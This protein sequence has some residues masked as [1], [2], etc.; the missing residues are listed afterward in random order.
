MLCATLASAQIQIGDNLHATMN[1]TVGFG[2]SGAYGNVSQSGHGIGFGFNG[3][4]NG[5]YFN[6]NFINFDFRPYFDRMQSNS[7]SQSIAR[8]TGIGGSAAFFGNSY[9]PG[10]ISYGRD[11]SNNSEYNVAGVPSV[12]TD[13][14]SQTF[15]VTWSLLLPN[16]PTLTATYGIGSSS[17][18]ITGTDME[19]S[20]SNKN[21]TL[22]SHY[23]LAGWDMYGAYGH[24]S[25]NF[26]TPAF[27]TGTSQELSSDGTQWTFNANHKIPIDGSVS[28]G[29]S[30]QHSSND[31]GDHSGGTSYS[32]SAGITP[33]GRLGLA[34]SI[35]YS[36]N[37]AESLAYS[38]LGPAAGS[39]QLIDHNAQTLFLSSSASLYVLRGLSINGHIT[40]RQEDYGFG[41][42]S[43][44]QYGGTVSYHTSH[45]WLG[46]YY[47]SGGVIDS[48]NKLG[49]TGVG[50]TGTVGMD[51]Q[52]GHWNVSAD[53]NYMQNV[54]TL[55]SIAT[56]SNM[57][58]GGSVRRRLNQSTFVSLFGRSTHSGLVTVE[59]TNNMSN[60]FGASFAWNGYSFSGNYSQSNGTGVLS[61]TGTLVPTPIGPVFTPDFIYFDAKALGVSA[62]KRFFRKFLVTSSYSQVK[63]STDQKLGLNRNSGDRFSVNTTY[64]FRRVSIV[65]GFTRSSQEF[66]TL[67]GGP[68][69]IN[70]YYFSI[71]RWFNIF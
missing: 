51:R 25:S 18:N 66:S 26:T 20:G 65:G 46:S 14:S 52:F 58:Y 13:S 23:K 19:S 30:H 12:L 54:Q 44:T 27:L 56:T 63:S 33:F 35:S 70:S 53:F 61:A 57:S 43:D 50:L 15:G 6:P 59:G 47:V 41:P 55:Y 22:S 24:Y 48:A 34:G 28:L 16:K 49:N 60:S 62:S 21:L 9:F 29:W 8:G 68:R 39:I 38:L 45:R 37:G 7:D 67:V 40:H 64:N 69:V 2:Y 32:A 17:S 10:S 4:M 1:G 31:N 36:T 42:I 71:N 5:Y 3:L 11:M